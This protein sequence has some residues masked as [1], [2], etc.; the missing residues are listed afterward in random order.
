V[1]LKLEKDGEFVKRRIL[2][3]CI[4]A[5]VL[6]G[7]QLSKHWA[8]T[9]LNGPFGT[10]EIKVVDNLLSFAYT[11]NWGIALGL[12]GDG[13]VPTKWILVGVST[14]AVVFVTGYL[15]KASKYEK[16]LMTALSLLLA[17]ILGNLVDRL[18]HGYVIDFITF[19]HNDWTFPVFN[20]ADTAISCGAALMAIDLFR[21]KHS[22]PAKTPQPA[23]ETNVSPISQVES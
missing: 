3:F 17:G 21:N 22:E 14:A 10:R 16:L 20:V 7:D 1:L 8:A 13:G 9:V 23:T 6:L 12:L 18:L 19:H 2:F 5:G 11:Q 4:S 15:F